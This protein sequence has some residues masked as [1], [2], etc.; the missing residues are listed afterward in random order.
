MGLWVVGH[1]NDDLRNRTETHTND[2]VRARLAAF[3]L[4]APRVD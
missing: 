1:F 2:K 3:G 4:V